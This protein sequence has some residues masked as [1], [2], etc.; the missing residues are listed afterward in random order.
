M[1][2]YMYYK[3]MSFLVYEYTMYEYNYESESD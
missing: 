1:G 2:M 3:L